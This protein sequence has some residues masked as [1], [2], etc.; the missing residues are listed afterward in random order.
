MSNLLLS[1]LGAVS[2]F[3]RSMIRERQRE[4]SRG[5]QGQETRLDSQAG[6][7]DPQPAGWRRE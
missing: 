1:M 5:L 4:A 6:R 7:R 3:E 2:E